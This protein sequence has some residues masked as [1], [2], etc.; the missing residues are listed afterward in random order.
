MEYNLINIQ[1]NILKRNIKIPTFLNLYVK[2]RGR[3]KDSGKER[4][5]FVMQ[6]LY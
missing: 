5:I 6:K 3:M 1:D 4:E 2:I